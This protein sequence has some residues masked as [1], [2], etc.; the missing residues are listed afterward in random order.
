ML[1]L[2]LLADLQILLQADTVDAGHNLFIRKHGDTP[3][4]VL[5]VYP[6]FDLRYQ[7]GSL[8]YLLVSL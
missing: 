2:Y 4:G 7:F 6:L 3:T 5:L 8:L 1:I